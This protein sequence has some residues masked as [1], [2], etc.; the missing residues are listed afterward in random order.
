MILLI[1]GIIILA[2]EGKSLGGFDHV[3]TLM[4][5]S[6]SAVSTYMSSKERERE[7]DQCA[8]RLFGVLYRWLNQWTRL[9]ANILIP[10]ALESQKVI[11]RSSDEF[12]SRRLSK[13]QEH[14]ASKH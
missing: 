2:R 1:R 6:T 9:P 13:I 5:C 4:M 12:S 10:C 3:G 11:A 8:L 14:E 7:P